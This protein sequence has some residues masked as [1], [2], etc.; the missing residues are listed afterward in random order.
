MKQRLM[1]LNILLLLAVVTAAM[2]L[3]SLVVEA[4]K[5]HAIVL[6]KYPLPAAPPR[7]APLPMVGVVAPEAYGET[8]Q[9][10]VMARDR[11]PIP[12]PPPPPPPPK[13]IPV[14]PMPSLPLA[15]GVF[16]IG[17][18]PLAM[19]SEKRGAPQKGFRV[20]DRIGEFKLL[21]FNNT[22]IQFEW[23]GQIVTRTMDELRDKQGPVVEQ[24]VATAAP[25]PAASS[26]SVLGGAS[27]KDKPEAPQSNG[28]PTT[29]ATVQG[30]TVK[31][32]R[33]GPFGNYTWT[34]SKAELNDAERAM[35]EGKKP[36]PGK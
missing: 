25:P 29:Q 24:A 7:P 2:H 20:G 32:V 11:N 23:D 3:R 35:I 5:R 8:I 30:D 10:L 17:D 34:K 15:Y 22:Q 27:A 28:E 9:R 14:K 4:D 12:E 6:D 18:A 13:E 33:P 36:A 31:F 16:S 1:L 26:S 21:G 19:L